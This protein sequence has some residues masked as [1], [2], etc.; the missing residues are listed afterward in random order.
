[1]FSSWDKAPAIYKEHN[2]W[3]SYNSNFVA[4]EQHEPKPMEFNLK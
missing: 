1:M 3:T 2:H 4:G